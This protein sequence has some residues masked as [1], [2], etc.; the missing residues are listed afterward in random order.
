MNEDMISSSPEPTV[1]LAVSSGMNFWW[2]IQSENFGAVFPDGTLWAPLRGSKGQKVASW[3]TLHGVRPGDIVLHFS[4]PFVCGISRVATLPS[5]AY[6]PLRGYKEPSD[7]AGVLALTDPLHEVLI[8]WE[9]VKNILPWG[10]GPLTVNGTL[11]RGYLFRLDNEAASRVLQQ[12]GLEATADHDE[13]KSSFDGYQGGPS[14]KWT[15]GA[16]RT[17]QRFLRSQQLQ[18]RGS[19][20]SLCGRPFPEEFLVA[21]HIKPRSAC[22]EMER[23]DTRN[24]SMLA[25]LFGCDALFEFGYVVVGDSGVIEPGRTAPE[26]IRERIESIVDEKCRA[27][28]EHSRGYFDWHRQTHLRERPIAK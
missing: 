15:L 8:P 13:G 26:Q 25:C 17:E 14:D 19:S 23:A 24:V 5:P 16:V 18:L 20:C 21:A 11:N 4:T 28:D 3:E 7:T 10:Q 27:Y 22:S 1:K 2:A 12:A 9:D 6:P